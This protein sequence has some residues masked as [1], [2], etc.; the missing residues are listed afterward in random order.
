MQQKLGAKWQTPV[1]M[2][3]ANN[4]TE[5]VLVH[6]TNHD[7]GRD[8]MKTVAWKV[9]PAYDGSFVARKSD[10]IDQLGLLHP[11]PNLRGVTEWVVSNRRFQL[12]AM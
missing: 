10:R 8:L 11:E 4:A 9:C 6:F 12:T 7:E 5:Y 3:G 1:R 2:L